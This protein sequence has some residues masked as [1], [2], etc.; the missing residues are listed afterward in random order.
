MI[1][2][3]GI[4]YTYWSVVDDVFVVLLMDLFVWEHLVLTALKQWTMWSKD[5][6]AIDGFD[7]EFVY[8]TCRQEN[9]WAN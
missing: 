6:Q 4:M 1:K 3:E 8:R 5:S 9:T 7:E 2:T